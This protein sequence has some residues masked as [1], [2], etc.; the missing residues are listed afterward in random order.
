MWTEQGNGM[1]YPCEQCNLKAKFAIK[2][3][4][5]IMNETISSIEINLIVV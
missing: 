1:F 4:K 2:K 5:T 3:T